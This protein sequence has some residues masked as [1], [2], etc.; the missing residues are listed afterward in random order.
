MSSI[1]SNG[2]HAP[3]SQRRHVA[4]RHLPDGVFIDQTAQGLAPIRQH[5][6]VTSPVQCMEW[7]AWEEDRQVPG[8]G[9][10]TFAVCEKHARGAGAGRVP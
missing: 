4:W 8:V 10:V 3:R 1:I 2:N 9:L 6:V 7:G 5:C